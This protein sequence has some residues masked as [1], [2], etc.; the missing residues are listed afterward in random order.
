MGFPI[1]EDKYA[2]ASLITPKDFWNYQKKRGELPTFAIPEGVIFC[3]SK[4]LV[5][6]VL[7]IH[8]TTLIEE[9]FGGTYLLHE[10]RDQIALIGKFGFGAPIAAKIL[11]DL[12]SFGVRK[13]VS[14]GTA[15]SL[16]KEITIGDVVVCDRALRDEGTSYHYIPPSEYVHASVEMTERIKK[17]LDSRGVKYTVGTSW[18]TDAIYRETAAE[19]KRYQKEGVLTVEMEASA[20]FAVAAYRNVDIGAMFTISD[21]VAELVWKPQFHRTEIPETLQLLFQAAVDALL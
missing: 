15:G 18:T 16:Q 20:L 13:F 3:Y 14:I 5:N 17:S 19:V 8:K 12:I 11:E 9:F 4:T 21:S 7:Q 2:E 10:T 6:H 1:F